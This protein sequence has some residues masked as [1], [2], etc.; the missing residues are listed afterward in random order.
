M[1]TYG[2]IQR[3][4]GAIAVMTFVMGL[5]QTAAAAEASDQ[6][7][8]AAADQAVAA[9]AAASVG[10][11]SI[12]DYFAHW[13]DRVDAAKAGQ[14]SWMTPIATVTPR[15][16]EEFRY[17]QYWEH[18]GT[19]AN[20]D[21]ADSGKGLELIPTE[22]NEILINLPPY[23]ALSHTKKPANGWGDWPF[24]TVK[25]RFISANAQNGDYIV[26]GFLG[27]QAPLGNSTFTNA[28]WMVTPTLAAGK[29]WG[30]F[31]VQATVGVPI[32]LSHEHQ[33]GTAVATNVAFQYH[34]GEFFW[35][36][37]EVNS[38]YWTDGPRQGKNQVFLTPG[39]IFGRFPLVGRSKF[40][41]G[42]AY[43]YAVSPEMTTKPV[44]TP[45]YRQSWISDGADH[46]LGGSRRPAPAPLSPSPIG[47]HNFAMRSAAWGRLGCTGLTSAERAIAST[48]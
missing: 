40:I 7:P 10:G 24:L 43:Q 45:T 18:K 37:V 36:E 11:N 29:G 46:L 25:Q 1:P 13:F 32:P 47:A 22:T 41:I 48:T 28:A 33:I 16:E 5:A 27:L 20:L 30:P 17:D 2:P 31:D 6:T 26:S 38:T 14:P 15:L 9:P 23:D 19:G 39:I 34:V 44:L 35:P 4:L 42:V 12:S 3:A 21:I 8:S